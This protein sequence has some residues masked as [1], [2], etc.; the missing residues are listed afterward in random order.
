ML[1]QIFPSGCNFAASRIGQLRRAEVVPKNRIRPASK[2]AAAE[3][4][5][6][7]IAMD[8]FAD[9]DARF[10]RP[11]MV[12]FKHPLDPGTQSGPSARRAQSSAGSSMSVL[13]MGS[14]VKISFPN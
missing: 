11:R 13:H 4:F 9:G 5:A 10:A 14:L 12:K 3:L 6:S 2:F 8:V 7:E 1:I